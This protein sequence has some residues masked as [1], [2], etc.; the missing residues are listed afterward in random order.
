M[1]QIKKMSQIQKMSQISK[2]VLISKK[3]LKSAHQKW[4]ELKN[5][6]N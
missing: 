1:S 5:D 3:R 4:P 2:I 6:Q